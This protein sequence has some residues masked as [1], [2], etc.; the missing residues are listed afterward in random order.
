MATEAIPKP[1]V[2][3][4]ASME[5]VPEFNPERAPVSTSSPRRA[6]VLTSGPE[7]ASDSESSPERAPVLQSSPVRAPGPEFSPERVPVPVFSPELCFLCVSTC[8]VLHRLVK[9]KTVILS[10][11]HIS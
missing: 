1:L 9:L 6:V 4:V 11:S 3:P 10:L 8:L 2:S 7:R 5:A